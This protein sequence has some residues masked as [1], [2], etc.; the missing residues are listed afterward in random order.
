MQ[1]HLPLTQ[2]SP[3]TPGKSHVVLL[4][5]SHSPVPTLQWGVDGRP[6]HAA[7]AAQPQSLVVLLQA[8]VGGQ[9]RSV[10]SFAQRCVAG[11]HT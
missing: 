11:L 1:P 4:V 2:T 6:A 9:P 5:H 10:Q 8:V 7:S 3:S